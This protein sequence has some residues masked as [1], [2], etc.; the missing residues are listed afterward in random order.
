MCLSLVQIEAFSLLL[1]VIARREVKAAIVA[2]GIIPLL[3]KLLIGENADI[4][5]QASQTLIS[6]CEVD[7]YRSE[8]IE[9]S[10]FDSL[11]T[12][13]KQITNKDARV[14]ITEAVGKILGRFVTVAF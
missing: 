12:G 5:R 2:A 10:I 13:M 1:N 6:L 7:Q 4:V 3:I 14:A 11:T 9:N 8:A